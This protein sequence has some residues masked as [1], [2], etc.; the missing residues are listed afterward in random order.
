MEVAIRNDPAAAAA[1]AA[2]GGGGGAAAARRQNVMEQTYRVAGI[3]AAFLRE[4]VPRLQVFWPP[5]H[6][7]GC[8][9][10][11][12]GEFLAPAASQPP[13]TMGIPL[14]SAAVGGR[15]AQQPRP[16]PGVYVRG[17][18]VR[19][20]PLDGALMAFLGKLNVSGRDRNDVDADELLEATLALMRKC[21]DM[22]ELRRLLTPL[23]KPSEP[24]TWIS[25]STR[26]LN[27]LLEVRPPLGRGAG[28]VPACWC[29]GVLVCWCAG[30][31]A[32]WR[33]GV[34]A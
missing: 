24:P 34:L 10:T 33:A 14:G 6:R 31:L 20:P 1:D 9:T 15:G 2:G 25:R 17:I 5:L 29:A 16:E 7:D 18:W 22:A 21:D 23:Q 8:L 12:S 11:R 4:A 28:G 27:Q 32:C 30:V 19:K 26:F 13:L 3:G